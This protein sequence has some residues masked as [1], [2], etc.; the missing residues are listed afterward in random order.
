MQLSHLPRTSLRYSSI[1]NRSEKILARQR[2][3]IIT[4]TASTLKKAQSHYLQLHDL[5]S[6]RVA[7]LGGASAVDHHVRRVHARVVA[8]PPAQVAAHLPARGRKRQ[9]RRFWRRGR[10]CYRVGPRA[11][12]R[13]FPGAEERPRA[14]PVIQSPASLRRPRPG[15]R[16]CSAAKTA[17]EG[18]KTAPPFDLRVCSC[19]SESKYWLHISPVSSLP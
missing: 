8:P 13:R 12:E 5:P 10:W 3:T 14:P 4:K 11:L 2:Q 9:G 17:P 1:T 15:R 16:G 19:R 18:A 6:A 7:R